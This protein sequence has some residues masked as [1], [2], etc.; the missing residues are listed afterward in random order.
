MQN[1]ILISTAA[2][3]LGLT[4]QVVLSPFSTA[5]CFHTV[6]KDVIIHVTHGKLSQILFGSRWGMNNNKL[7]CNIVLEIDFIIKQEVLKTSSW[8]M[9]PIGLRSSTER[10]TFQNQANE[11][12]S[13]LIGHF[14]CAAWSQETKINVN[15]QS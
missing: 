12:N 13:T 4:Y 11:V 5:W 6:F 1:S 7:T 15:H 10:G 14:I 3:S 2:T 9:C 8:I